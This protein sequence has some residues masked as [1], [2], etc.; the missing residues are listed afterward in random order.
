MKNFARKL[1]WLLALC[2][3]LALVPTALAASYTSRWEYNGTTYD[4]LQNAV[5]AV[6]AGNT[7]PAVIKMTTP[8]DGCGVV[9][10]GNRNIVFDFNGGTYE[11]GN[12][13][14]GSTGTETNGFQLLKGSTVKFMNGTLTS[15]VAKLLIQNYSDLTLENVTVEAPASSPMLC[16]VSNN[17]GSLTVKGN[18]QINAVG[19]Q[20]AFDVW[21]GMYDVY[22]DGIEVIFDESFTGSVSGPI[23]YGAKNTTTTAN[24]TDWK[25]KATITMNGNGDFSGASFDATGVLDNV[26][27]ANI[28]INGGVVPANTPAAFLNGETA[29]R[30]DGSI[31][32]G[33]AAVVMNIPAAYGEKDFVS[34]IDWKKVQDV[35]VP[36]PEEE[37]EAYTLKAPAYLRI[38]KATTAKFVKVFKVDTAVTVYEIAD[39]WATVKVGDLTGYV[40]ADLL[41]K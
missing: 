4:N 35:V 6:P 13:T 23:E 16:L 1:S 30:A 17:F 15:Q 7:E 26:A 27:D 37:G 20:V 24:N 8:G 14:V 36:V 22:A 31:V 11:I 19:S 28:T 18:T 5:N 33:A 41:K 38:D 21:Y 34:I 25:D 39:G 3:L 40:K 9:V 29:T 12:P 10:D 32:V 2:M